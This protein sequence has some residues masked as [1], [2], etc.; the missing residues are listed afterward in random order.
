[1]TAY[2]Y[3]RHGAFGLRTFTPVSSV[4]VYAVVPDRIPCFRSLRSLPHDMSFVIAAHRLWSHG[5]L[6]LSYRYSKGTLSSREVCGCMAQGL[7]DD[8]P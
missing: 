4:D 1:M 5:N 7:D 8:L 6:H 3:E 2:T